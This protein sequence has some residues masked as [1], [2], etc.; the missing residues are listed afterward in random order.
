MRPWAPSVYGIPEEQIIGSRL[1]KELVRI[2]DTIAINR[3]PVLSFLNDKSGKPLGIYEAI[4]KKPVFTVG[5]SDG[6]LEMLQWTDTQKNS[7]KMYIHHT[8][9]I[10]EWAYDSLSAVGR[11]KKGLDEARNKSW[12][13]VDMKKDWK[14]V[15]PFELK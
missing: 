6:D 15:F 14:V 13:V 5:N 11:L 10:R 8:D 9:A 3:L 1:K 7:F 12:S 4:G 2:E